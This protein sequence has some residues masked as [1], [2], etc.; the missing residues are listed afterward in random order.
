[1]KHCNCSYDPC[2]HKGICCDCLRRHLSKKQLPA[3]CFPDEIAKTDERRFE[4]FAE[5]VNNKE[6]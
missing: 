1:M 5:L 4:K 6:I 2:P 3:C